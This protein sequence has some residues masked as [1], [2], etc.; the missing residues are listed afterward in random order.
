MPIQN[1]INSTTPKNDIDL[2]Q[3][4][5]C[6][7]LTERGTCSILDVDACCGEKCSFQQTSEKAEQSRQQWCQ[8]LSS[9][10]DARQRKIA[11]K[12]YAGTMPWKTN[13]STAVP[14]A[15][16]LGEDECSR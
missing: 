12:Y 14:P 7:C 6:I 1:R 9:Y 5:D 16:R 8:R 11:K 13:G 15:D 2:S 3:L 4:P 10:D